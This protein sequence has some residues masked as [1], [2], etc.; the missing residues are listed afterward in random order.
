MAEIASAKRRRGMVSTFLSRIRKDIGK[1]EEKEEFSPLDEK[2]LRWLKE[3]AME[4]DLEFEEH[5]EEVPSFIEEEDSATLETEE[6]VFDEHV[7]RVTDFIQ[8]L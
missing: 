3:L 7:D 4:H 2:K 8:W 6:T 5:H 1:M